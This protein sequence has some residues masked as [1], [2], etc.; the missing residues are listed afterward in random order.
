MIEK[1][2][3]I[4][5]RFIYFPFDIKIGRL[6]F[7]CYRHGNKKIKFENLTKDKF[8]GTDR[9]IRWNFSV[10]GWTFDFNIFEK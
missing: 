9:T 10:L 4:I 3:Y 7:Y 8:Y 5:E 2:K 1:I 6:N